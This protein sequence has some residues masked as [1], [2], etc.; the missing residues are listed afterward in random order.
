[1]ES[2]EPLAKEMARVRMAAGST[3]PVLPMAAEM[4]QHLSHK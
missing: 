3:V 2:L 4:V 1:M